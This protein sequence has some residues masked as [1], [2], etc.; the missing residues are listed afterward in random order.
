MSNVSSQ[1]I[2]MFYLLTTFSAQELTEKNTSFSS[3]DNIFH[4]FVDL[5]ILWTMYVSQAFATRFL[6]KNL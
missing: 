4:L 5:G 6:E 1:T 3:L 2:N